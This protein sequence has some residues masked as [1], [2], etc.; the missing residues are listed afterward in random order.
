[1]PTSRN[2]LFALALAAALA[3]A[4]ARPAPREPPRPARPPARTA[5][6]LSVLLAARMPG[7]RVTPDTAYGYVGSGFYLA[8][9]AGRTREELE[10]LPFG[11]PD[12][13]WAGVV[14]CESAGATHEVYRAGWGEHG[15]AAGR[16]VFYGDPGLIREVADALAE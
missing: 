7:L 1:M 8:R 4:L 13:G 16:F 3:L 15:L 2:R 14:F 12:A 9:D 6:E 10:R 11:T 5:A